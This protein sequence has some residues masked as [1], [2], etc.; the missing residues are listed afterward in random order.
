MKRLSQELPGAI[1]L[2]RVAA[3][4]ARWAREHESDAALCVSVD[5]LRHIVASRLEW[6]M[7]VTALLAWVRHG[8][9]S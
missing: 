8:G 5:M 6:A 7:A 2:D 9:E 1:D 4:H 3:T